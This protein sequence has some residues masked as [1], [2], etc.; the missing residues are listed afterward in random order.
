LE[1]TR[2]RSPGTQ[3]LGCE[4][5]Q[6]NDRHDAD[7]E[8]SPTRGD[9]GDDLHASSLVAPLATAAMPTSGEIGPSS[10]FRSP[11]RAHVA[12]ADAFPCPWIGLAPLVGAR[13]PFV[14]AETPLVR[15]A[16]PWPW[17]A[18]SQVARTPL[19]IATE[20]VC[21]DRT[22]DRGLPRRRQPVG[23]RTGW[24]GL[25]AAGAAISLALLDDD[26][27]PGLR[28]VLMPVATAADSLF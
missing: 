23:Y 14:A 6:G 2:P 12:R 26:T 21:L 22:R 9:L 20:E 11:S 8:R 4:L 28:R 5:Q 16:V 15:N 17:T 10:S 24:F 27:V 7:A 25:P 19:P 3:V 18:V 13:R 1:R